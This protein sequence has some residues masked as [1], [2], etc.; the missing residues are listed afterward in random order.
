VTTPL[1]LDAAGVCN[2]L[3]WHAKHGKRAGAPRTDLVRAL[4]RDGRFPPPITPEL[5]AQSWR[6]S[7][8]KVLEYVDRG[9]PTEQAS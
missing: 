3:G 7:T 4:Y 2:L 9:Y 8:A 5:P 1:T 6:W